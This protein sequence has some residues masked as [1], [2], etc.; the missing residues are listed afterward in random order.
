MRLEQVVGNL[1]SNAIKYSPPG[2]SVVVTVARAE[3]ELRIAVADRGVGIAPDDVPHLFEPFHRAGATMKAASGV[4]LGL[5]IARKIVE[6]H[7]GR[8]TV[9]SVPGAG[10]TFTVH[11]PGEAAWPSS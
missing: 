5:F 1:V 6:A 8:V 7:G 2:G 4:G 3:G 9:D 10:S 11:L